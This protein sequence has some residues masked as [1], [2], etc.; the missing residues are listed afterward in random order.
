MEKLAQ[1]K[2][3]FI[4]EGIFH[5]DDAG[6]IAWTQEL[7]HL[8]HGEMLIH[9]TEDTS[10]PKVAAAL[11]QIQAAGRKLSIDTCYGVP[12]FVSGDALHEMFGP[13]A[14]N[15]HLWMRK[16]KQVFDPNDL[17]D[18]LYFITARGP[19]AAGAQLPSAISK[20]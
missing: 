16:V 18:A 12:G 13:H 19:G 10:A 20:D 9:T 1:V 17:S 4:E 5:D 8:G 7:G 3:R 6:Y 2:A 11:G 14:C 15:Y